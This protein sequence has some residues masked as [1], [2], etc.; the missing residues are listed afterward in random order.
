MTHERDCLLCLPE[1]PFCVSVEVDGWAPVGHSKRQPIKKSLLGPLKALLILWFSCPRSSIPVSWLLYFGW[2]VGVHAVEMHLCT[3]LQ[4]KRKPVCQGEELCHSLLSRFLNAL[5]FCMGELSVIWPK[6]ALRKILPCTEKNFYH[7]CAK[8]GP[9]YELRPLFILPLENR[10]CSPCI[11]ASGLLKYPIINLWD[12][13]GHIK[14]CSHLVVENGHY[15]QWSFCVFNTV[16]VSR[17]CI[18]I[19]LS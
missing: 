15:Q 8:N 4:C 3:K 5:D 7:T 9:L 14:N 19:Y 1:M 12:V 2:Q 18:G 17:V 13:C 11:E 6:A 16:C 10:F